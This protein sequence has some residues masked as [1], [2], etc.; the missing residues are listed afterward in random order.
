MKLL[1]RLVGRTRG[2]EVTPVQE[3][4]VVLDT[5][6]AGLNPDVDDLLAIGAV[7]VDAFGIRIDDSFECV[8]RNDRVTPA[9]NV[10]VHGIGHEAQREGETRDV[11][12]AGF[13]DFVSGAPC[14]AFHADFD[15]KVLKRAFALAG[16]EA[17]EP[18]W[19]DLAPLAAALQPQAHRYGGRSLDDW[20]AAFAIDVTARHNAAG[21]ALATAEL[22]L[23]LR[24]IAARQGATNF[25]GLVKVARQQK[26][27]GSAD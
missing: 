6:T 7:A 8:L 16:I 23:H 27:L 25:A 12:L 10:V 14:I 3:R 19:L 22:L 20:L 17:Q 18:A 1:A 15:R 9:D 5:E 26:W 24:T 11:A 2:A 4:W 21:D 13:R